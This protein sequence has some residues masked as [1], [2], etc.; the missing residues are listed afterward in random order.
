MMQGDGVSE[1]A[2]SVGWLGGKRE[3]TEGKGRRE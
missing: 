3:G 2:V 1:R